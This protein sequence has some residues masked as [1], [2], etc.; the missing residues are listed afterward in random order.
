[1][2]IKLTFSEKHRQNFFSGILSIKDEQ[3]LLDIFQDAKKNIK[4]SEFTLTP[5]EHF[6]E[7]KP[8]EFFKVVKNRIVDD[9]LRE[10]RNIFLLC[11]TEPIL[12]NAVFG[13][14]AR[15]DDDVDY[16]NYSNLEVILLGKDW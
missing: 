12:K 8:I 13:L 6:V 1:M 3:G 7:L 14:V 4:Q 10:V 11:F 15:L 16:Y 5:I 2:D 9:S